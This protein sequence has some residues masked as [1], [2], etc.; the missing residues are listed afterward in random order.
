MRCS[1]CILRKKEKL[2]LEIEGP[3]EIMATD[4]GDA[5]SFVPF[6]SHEREAFNSLALAIVKAKKGTTGTFKVK[7]MSEGLVPA[8]VK[9]IAK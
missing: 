1:E 6:K 5:T 8:E 9:V 3:G 2:R 7:V 4:N